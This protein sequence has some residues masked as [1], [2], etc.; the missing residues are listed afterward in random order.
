MKMIYRFFDIPLGVLEKREDGFIYN[1]FPEGEKYVRETVC[2]WMLEPYTWFNSVDL[3]IKELP[4]SIVEWVMDCTR[5]ERPDLVKSFKILE[6]D[7]IWERLVKIT[8]GNLNPIDFN[9]VAYKEEL[10]ALPNPQPIPDPNA[11]IWDFS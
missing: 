5:P 10:L 8:K 11:D 2:D 3:E 1:S 9:L 7:S 4:D 6:T